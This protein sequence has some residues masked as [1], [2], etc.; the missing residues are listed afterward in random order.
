MRAPLSHDRAMGE[1]RDTGV[2]HE[3]AFD[4]NARALIDTRSRALR[5]AEG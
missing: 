4:R 1:P 2:K 5:A 3:R